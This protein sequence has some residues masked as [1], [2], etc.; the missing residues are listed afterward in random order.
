MSNSGESL[1]KPNPVLHCAHKIPLTIPLSWQWSTLALF[2]SGFFLSFFSNGSRSDIP[3]I[4]HFPSCTLNRLI[5]SIK[6]IPYDLRNSLSIALFLSAFLH[7]WAAKRFFTRT[8]WI[9]SGLLV[10]YHRLPRSILSFLLHSGQRSGRR[11]LPGIYGISFPQSK[12]NLSGYSLCRLSLFFSRH[13]S[14]HPLPIGA[15]FPQ[16]QH[17]PSALYFS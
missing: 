11:R 17:R 14:H 15:D 9:C 2:L 7:S 10:A 3:Q 4:A 13:K 12:Q 16:L 8:R 5:R 1:K 6:E